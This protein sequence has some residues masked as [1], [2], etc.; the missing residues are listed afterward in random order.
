MRQKIALVLSGGGARGIAHIGVI[1]ALLSQG[2][3]IEEIAGTSMGALVGGLYSAGGLDAFKK[4]LVNADI[5]EVI[6][7]LDFSL[8]SPGLI[9]AN[10]IME[11]I[12]T[13][14]S[15]KDLESL[16]ILFT[17]IATDLVTENEVVFTSGNLLQAIRAS[18]AIPSIFTPVYKGQQVLV[19][20][21]LLNNIPINHIRNKQL[22]VVAVCVNSE[23]ALNDFQKNIMLKNPKANQEHLNKIGKIKKHLP[24]FV[25]KTSESERKQ[26]GY[27]E[28]IDRSIHISIGKISRQ[29]IQEHPPQLLI[30][31][32]RDICGTFDFLKADRLISIGYEA[33]IQG[34]K[35]W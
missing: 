22:P 7:M 3:E 4:W 35:D 17:A 2:F 33:G 26:M 10:K 29:I 27:A 19:D 21:G 28:I 6:K 32:P 13:F 25:R 5:K 11:K 23:I 15:I 16:P 20:G 24:K 8:K 9:K 18:I 12:G 34:L 31:I 30:D 14:V 1:E